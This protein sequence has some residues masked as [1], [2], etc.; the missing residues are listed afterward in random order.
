VKTQFG[1]I[2]VNSYLE[3]TRS[4]AFAATEF[5]DPIVQANV[6][7][8][9]FSDRTVRAHYPHDRVKDCKATPR[10]GVAACRSGQQAQST[11][12]RHADT[13]ALG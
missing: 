4:I 8:R 6:I 9:C 13:L 7:A 5:A 10:A 3:G 2:G 11:Q 12:I 1:L